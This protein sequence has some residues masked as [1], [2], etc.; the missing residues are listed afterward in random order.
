MLGSRK[1]AE[2]CGKYAT[3]S[4]SQDGVRRRADEAE[5]RTLPAFLVDNFLRIIE[6]APALHFAAVAGVGRLGRRRSAAAALRTSLSVM[7]L[8][9]QTIMEIDIIDNAN[10][11]Q[12]NSVLSSE[13]GQEH[14][15]NEVDQEVR[16]NSRE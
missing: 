1:V 6:A 7:R 14:V 2:N 13:E 5:V 9:T 12:V 10:H 8:Q 11:S 3:E 16:D 15:R 4:Q